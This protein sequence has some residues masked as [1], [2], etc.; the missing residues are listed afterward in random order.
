M[1]NDDLSKKFEDAT[2]SEAKAR[3]KSREQRY[4]TIRSVATFSAF[5]VGCVIG[6]AIVSAI[7]DKE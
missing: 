6:G 4:A 5:V 2:N 7:F 1:C 3:E